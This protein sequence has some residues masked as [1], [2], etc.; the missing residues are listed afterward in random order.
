MK[1]Q[2]FLLIIA[3]NINVLLFAQYMSYQINYAGSAKAYVNGN[4]DV[5][6]FTLPAGTAITSCTINVNHP[7]DYYLSGQNVQILNP[8]QVWCSSNK[9]DQDEMYDANGNAYSKLTLTQPVLTDFLVQQSYTGYTEAFLNNGFQSIAQFPVTNI[10]AGIS[11]EYAQPTINIQSN[12][13][14][15]SNKAH[16]LTSGCTK[17]QDAV[18][19]IAQWVIGTISYSSSSNGNLDMNASLVFDRKSGNCAGYTNLIIAMLRSVGIPARFVG[20]VLLRYPYNIS[21]LGNTVSLGSSGPGS[22]AVYEVY[23][24]DKDEW[25]MADAQNTLNF[26]S[27]HFIRHQHGADNSDKLLA[28]SYSYTGAHPIVSP[29]EMCGTIT[30]F[31]N[32]YAYNS[33][34]TFQTTRQN[35]HLLSVFPGH[36]TGINDKVEITSG[37][38]NFKTGEGVSYTSTFT[39]FQGNTW[40][41][42][43][44]WSIKLYH[45]NGFYLYASDNNNFSSWSKTTNP[46]LPDYDWL[47]DSEGRIFGEVFLAATLNDG[48]IIGAKMPLSVE[49]CNGVVVSN[50]NITSNATIPGCYITV[51]NVSVQNN[52]NLILNSEMGITI[53]NNFTVNIGSTFETQ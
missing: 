48:D 47:L 11:L 44:F 17:M 5:V 6:M 49:E 16:A 1:K 34:S 27:T 42:N 2:L 40:P 7:N 36:A 3:I 12:D 23:Y 39:S 9:F 50:Q 20:G 53:N 14:D 18:Q 37:T 29:N 52:S 30:S 38:N 13:P 31:N 28:C 25:I 4:T 45:T 43:R 21:F 19:K 10:P 24:P 51:D 26:C 8:P 32:N 33:Y 35:A 22:H 15:I 41:V 46:I